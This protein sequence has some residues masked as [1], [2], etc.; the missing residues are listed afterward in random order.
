MFAPWLGTRVV[1]GAARRGWLQCWRLPPQAAAR[2]RR[3]PK[4]RQAAA[5]S[6]SRAEV[7]PAKGRERIRRALPE[8]QAL[9]AAEAC[10]ATARAAEKGNSVAGLTTKRSKLYL[11]FSEGD[12][13]TAE[14]GGGTGVVDSVNGTGPVDGSGRSLAL[15]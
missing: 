9:S 12:G 6:L 13:D 2:R 7:P 10:V 14:A 5:L 4:D 15:P 1:A 11:G 8:V 3:G